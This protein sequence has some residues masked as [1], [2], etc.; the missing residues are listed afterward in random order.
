MDT[1][2]AQQ[3]IDSPDQINVSYNGTPIYIEKVLEDANMARIYPLDSPDREED[4]PLERLVE[5]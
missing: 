3:I 2:R 5:H 1:Q 4:V